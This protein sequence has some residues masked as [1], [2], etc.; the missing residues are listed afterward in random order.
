MKKYLI[1]GIVILLGGAF[2]YR[3]RTHAQ[4]NYSVTTSSGA[5]TGS[6]SS[7]YVNVD[8]SSWTTYTCQGGTW[9]AKAFAPAALKGTTGNIGGS[10]LAIGGVASGTVT[11]SGAV[12]GSPCIASTSDGTN[13]LGLGADV[14]CTVTSANTATVTV[15]AIVAL[16]PPSKTYSVTIP[17]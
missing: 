4:S 6:C 15:A 3:L 1:I 11:I 9:T 13:I 17:Q 2:I 5:P 8:V 14:S 16:T 10:L 7:N 12:A